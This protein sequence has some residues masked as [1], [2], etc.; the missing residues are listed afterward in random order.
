MMFSRSNQIQAEASGVADKLLFLIR[1]WSGLL[2]LSSRLLI[3]PKLDERFVEGRVKQFSATALDGNKDT[4]T[5]LRI[6]FLFPLQTILV[7]SG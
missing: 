6:I 5:R 7:E 2:T 4:S 3:P 1:I